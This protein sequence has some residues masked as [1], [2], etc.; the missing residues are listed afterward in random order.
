MASIA[1]SIIGCID[2][3]AY[4]TIFTR[5]M[6]LPKK[7]LDVFFPARKAVDACRDGGGAVVIDAFTYVAVGLW[8]CGMVR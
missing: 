4:G 1:L 2:Y 6:F 3:L 8:R 5:A 7:K